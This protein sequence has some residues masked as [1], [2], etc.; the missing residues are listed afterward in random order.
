[1]ETLLQPKYFDLYTERP[2]SERPSRSV[3]I[4][5]IVSKRTK[6]PGAGAGQKGHKSTRNHVA[7]EHVLSGG[8]IPVS[9]HVYG[10]PSSNPV[11]K[12]SNISGRSSPSV[13]PRLHGGIGHSF[14]SDLPLDRGI[15]DCAAGTLDNALG[16]SG[17]QEIRRNTFDSATTLSL[18]PTWV[19]SS[20]HASVPFLQPPH[21]SR[22]DSASSGSSTSSGLS[23]IS[24]GDFSEE[25]SSS[26]LTTK[27]NALS[28]ETS[29]ALSIPSG[30]T[31]P[32]KWR[33]QAQAI[34]S[35]DEIIQKNTGNLKDPSRT[36]WA[37]S[38]A[39]QPYSRTRSRVV[40]ETSEISKS[41]SSIDSIAAEVT[42]S[43]RAGDTSSPKHLHHARSLP[44]L[45]PSPPMY[46]AGHDRLPPE[47]HFPASSG[48]LQA[49]DINSHIANHTTA[50]KEEIVQY[51]RSTR[52]TRLVTLQ[53]PPNHS[54]V[55]SLADVGLK[56]GH[57][58]LVFLGLGCVRYLV[59]LYD[60]LA[61]ALGLRLI[62]IDRWGLGRTG[63]VPDDRRGF[64]EWATVV[65]E[66]L[67]QLRIQRFS[68][69]AHSAG[70]PY[71]LATSLRLD[72]RVL[73]SI[74]LLAPWI[75]ANAE[76]AAGAYKW[77]KY[78]PTSVIRTAQAA[79][80]KIQSW[81]LGKPPS[82]AVTGLGFDPK[83]P[84]SSEYISPVLDHLCY[85]YE[86]IGE[87]L[88][89]K[90][91]RTDSLPNLRRTAQHLLEDSTRPKGSSLTQTQ[92]MRPPTEARTS[93][94]RLLGAL[95]AS[96]TAA[97]L[98]RTE[99]SAS[100]P[101]SN[102][103][104]SPYLSNHL[105]GGPSTHNLSISDTAS[106]HSSVSMN[107]NISLDSSSAYSTT[108]EMEFDLGSALMRAS[109]AESLKGITSDLLTLLEK[110]SRSVGFSYSNVE[111]SV[112][113]WHGA[114]DEKISLQSVLSLEVAMPNCEVTI[115]PGADH[116]LMTNVAVVM[117][118]LNSVAR[119]RGDIQ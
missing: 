49:P 40:T 107:G 20:S 6:R 118:V 39:S 76:N 60:E 97:N 10:P 5:H 19:A 32:P 54:L 1:M 28:S 22:S 9:R 35:I 65:E 75:N 47:Q 66:A 102:R 116:S 26:L 51:L 38:A 85:E 21:I 17:A 62:C 105:E 84:V 42:Q 91:V 48:Y 70:C 58:V 71:A 12:T 103:S 93:S 87:K 61:K 31:T 112:K 34:L 44:S 86:D 83:A 30:P 33:P 101:I 41:R 108:K 111:R 110:T 46:P 68:I 74:H 79:E 7:A 16:N 50:R 45:P 119:E 90:D 3:A 109:H 95:Y 67:D 81:K 24:A 63:D 36:T 113:V 100:R 57:P 64:L 80:W 55:L 2:T 96:P 11:E 43:M 117:R 59:A 77:L 72:S 104:N 89:A 29:I 8:S 4:N 69:L 115:I 88:S 15:P 98:S 106:E 114:K 18:L 56:E 13:S 78:V 37:S 14:L 23:F 27:D 99:I 53:K 92:M 82:I 52:L 25:Q 94:R 73:G